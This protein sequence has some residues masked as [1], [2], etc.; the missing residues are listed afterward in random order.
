MGVQRPT[1]ILD[2]LPE[3]SMCTECLWNPLGYY[4]DQFENQH[5]RP[6]V[7]LYKEVDMYSSASTSVASSSSPSRL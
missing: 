7:P 2:F 6:R 3:V 5:S 4:R 1:G